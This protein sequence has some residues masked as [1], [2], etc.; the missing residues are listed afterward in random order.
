MLIDRKGIAERFGFSK[1]PQHLGRLMR[2]GR[3]PQK[4]KIGNRV[5]WV[6]AEVEEWFKAHIANRKPL[7]SP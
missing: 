1:T 3:F 2:A 7:H 5:Y 4:V 6:L